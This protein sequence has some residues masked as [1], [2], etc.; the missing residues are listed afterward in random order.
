MERERT[1][2]N[3]PWREMAT[4]ADQL[5]AEL[6]DRVYALMIRAGE[7]PDNHRLYSTRIG[8]VAHSVQAR[9]EKEKN[10]A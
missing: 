10:R 2:E 5:Y 9:A 4:L 8:Q 6:G 3:W 1:A 7:N